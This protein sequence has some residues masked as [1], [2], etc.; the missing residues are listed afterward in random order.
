MA[1]ERFDRAAAER[2]LQRAIELEDVRDDEPF[3][4]LSEATLR[5]AADELGI[6][7]T[8][9]QQAAAEERL[10][11]LAGAARRLDRIVG[12]GAVTAVRVVDGRRGDVLAH[13]DEWLRRAAFRR[14]RYSPSFAEYSRR[15]D[16]VAVAQRAVRSVGGHEGLKTVRNLRVTAEPIGVDSTVLAFVVDLEGQRTATLAGGSTLAGGGSTAAVLGQVAVGTH[17]LWLGI[18][19]S[20]AAGYGILR[21]R[22]RGLGSVETELQGALDRIAAADLPPNAFAGVRDRV[23]AQGFGRSVRRQVARSTTKT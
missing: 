19:G 8:A 14:R 23:V 7:A 6:P 5:E 4:G 22:A 9:V 11:V 3:R 16:P 2:I 1:E 17:W 15:G 18:P 10:G 12:P 13:A 21:A 20:A